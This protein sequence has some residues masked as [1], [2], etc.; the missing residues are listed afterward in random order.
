MTFLF[1]AVMDDYALT[2]TLFFITISF[3]IPFCLDTKREKK[4]KAV[5]IWPYFVM[6]CK[7][8]ESH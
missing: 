6:H 4:V 7:K 5:L 1:D 8:A 2:Y 3:L